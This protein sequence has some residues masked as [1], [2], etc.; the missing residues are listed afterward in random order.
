MKEEIYF[1]LQLFAEDSEDEVTDDGYVGDEDEENEDESDEEIDESEDEDIDEANKKEAEDEDDVE[2]EEGLDK[3]TKAII[4][5]KKEAKEAKERIALLEAE[6]AEANNKKELDKIIDEKIESGYSEVEAKKIARLELENKNMKAKMVDFQ[7]SELEK[8][9]PLITNHKQ[10]II[11]LQKNL[12]NSKIEDIYLAKFFTGSQSDAENVAKQRLLYS[13]KEA[14][15][16]N[17]TKNGETKS[18]SNDKTK[19][20]PS[21][22]RA[23][24]ILKETRPSMTKSDFVKLLDDDEISED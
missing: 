2:N 20:S 23:Y 16:K 12:P 24:K 13:Q 4:R 6:L 1:D 3:K 5:H 17:G 22:L 14:N 19:L 7:F 21:D 11:E 18:M 9:F 15:E 10:E 8:R